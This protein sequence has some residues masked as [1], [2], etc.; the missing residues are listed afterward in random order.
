MEN[1]IE[2]EK[3]RHSTSHVMAQAV[4]EL[5]PGTKLA[6]GPAIEDG[7][8]Y[9]FNSPRTFLPEDLEKIEQKMKEI[10]KNDYKFTSREMSKEEAKKFFGER[11]EKYK[12]ELLE[13]IPDE[14][15]TLYQDG[16][17]IDLCRGPH[18]E[19][20]KQIKHFKLLSVAGAY[21]RGDEKREQLQRIYGTVF[22]TKEELAD[23]LNK[24]EEAKK[25]DHRKLGVQLDL[26]STHEQVGAGLV[27]WHPKGTIIRNIIENLWKEEH[28]KHGYQLVSTPHIASEE[29]YKTSGH[30]E[31][32]SDM[33]YS[34]MDID[35][36]PFRVKPMNCPN[37]IMIYKTKLHSY[38][39]LPVRY[40]ELGTVYRY[41]K[42][43]VLHGLLRV[44]GFTIDDAH[45]FCKLDQLEQEMLNIFDFTIKFLQTFGFREYDIYLATKP[46][47]FVGSEENWA[48]AID[49]LKNAMEKTKYPYRIDEGGGAFYGPKVDIK[50]KDVLGRAW[51]CSTIQFDFNLAERF[52]ITYRDE[53]GKD[54]RVFMI[55]RALLGSMER[56]F[57]VL[58]EHYAGAFP[59]WLSPVQVVVINI[60]ESQKDY[61]ENV[62]VS[63]K[64]EGIRA[65][66]DLSNERLNYK[67]REA[68]V[69]KIPYI[70]IV[71]DKEKQ[72]RKV[73]A[74]HSGR[75]IGQFE[76]NEF[77]EKLKSELKQKINNT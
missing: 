27:H 64:N 41:E 60:S 32:Y 58:I 33:I 28:T 11:N 72:S 21:W 7:F 74:R 2:L 66:S 76:L 24:L 6:I 44:R 39:E 61:A 26:F 65:E 69:N 40:A 67:I 68:T 10:V 12:V 20:T 1:K 3:L 29:I 54:E 13:N 9:D 45:I 22:P 25:R 75:D 59:L 19:S 35:G 51:Q 50:I 36:R 38:R 48:K 53:S 46:E 5:F 16:D 70:V 73:S 34:P 15:V 42:S 8:Y 18:I 47:K 14:K 31:K 49:S 43:G 37:H 56:F 4:L 17:F 62:T 30:L 57:G 63:L 77:I 23:Y 71:G 52:D 55:H